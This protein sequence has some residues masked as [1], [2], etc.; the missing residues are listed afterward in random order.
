MRLIELRN[1]DR[2]REGKL[3]STVVVM[4]GKQSVRCVRVYD[5]DETG[6]VCL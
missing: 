4:V 1:R 3:L 6:C 2:G 5:R